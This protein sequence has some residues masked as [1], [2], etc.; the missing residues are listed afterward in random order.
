MLALSYESMDILD[1]TSSNSSPERRL[2]VAILERAILDYVGNEKK[3]VIEAEE[4]LFGDLDDQTM[5]APLEYSFPWV[6]MQ[7]E[8]DTKDIA[9]KIK[10]MPKRGSS[11]VAPWYFNKSA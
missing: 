1:Y 4:W 2:L 5:L 7:L 8:L 3:E 9:N 6:C 11:R 10:I